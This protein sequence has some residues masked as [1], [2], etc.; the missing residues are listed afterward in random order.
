MSLRASQRRRSHIAMR[1]R[2][3]GEAFDRYLT[4]RNEAEAARE[5][6]TRWWRATER[7]VPYAAYAAALD[8]EE[9]AATAYGS[10]VA[11]IDRLPDTDRR[12]VRAQTGTPRR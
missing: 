6:Y 11:R 8:R 4:W 5:A 2:L 3:L 1:E 10:V 7:A 12:L 9:C